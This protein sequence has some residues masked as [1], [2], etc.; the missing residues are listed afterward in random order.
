MVTVRERGGGV[1]TSPV[2]LTSD[3]DGSLRVP[4]DRDLVSA[5]ELTVVNASDRT[6]CWQYIGPA[7]SCYGLPSDDGLAARV[8]GVA[9]R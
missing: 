1:S 6:R 4:F 9:S 7:Y 5:V 8:R 3:G 2:T